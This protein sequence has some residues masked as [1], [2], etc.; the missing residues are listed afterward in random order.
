MYLNF[1]WNRRPR[2]RC[3]GLEVF[4]GV[5]FIAQCIIYQEGLQGSIDYKVFR[6][7]YLVLFH[8][9]YEHLFEIA[10]KLQY[11]MQLVCGAGMTGFKL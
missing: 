2:L 4:C 5:V 3:T 6:R 11:Q 8:S 7:T 9:R 10:T 1:C